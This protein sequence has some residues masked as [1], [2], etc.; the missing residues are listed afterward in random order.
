MKNGTIGM[1]AHSGNSVFT[2]RGHRMIPPRL[3]THV[4]IV[5]D[6]S[7]NLIYLD[8]ILDAENQVPSSFLTND[9]AIADQ[10]EYESTHP[11]ADSADF[12]TVVEAPGATAYTITFDPRT[13]TEAN[14]DFV[15]FYKDD[16]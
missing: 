14:Y 16:R 10:V 3:A 6:R 1:T 12:Y 5:Q 13:K 8:G 11:Y 7:R 4:T 2:S 9:S 15:R